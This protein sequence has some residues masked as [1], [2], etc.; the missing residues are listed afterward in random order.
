MC[1]YW[2][3]VKMSEVATYLKVLNGMSLADLKNF[4]EVVLDYDFNDVEGRRKSDKVSFIINKFKDTPK[5]KEFFDLLG[6]LEKVHVHKA[7]RYLNEAYNLPAD[8]LR[9]IKRKTTLLI[10]LYKYNLID[11]IEEIR[12][13]SGI[14]EYREK[15]RYIL[16]ITPKSNLFVNVKE[17]LTAFYK[18]WNQKRINYLF[19]EVVSVT[20]DSLMIRVFKESDRKIARQFKFRLSNNKPQEM[21]PEEFSIKTTEYY[22]VSSKH[23]NIKKINENTFEIVFNFD[24]HKDVELVEKLFSAIFGNKI[25]IDQLI[26]STPKF[27][28][29]IVDT[30][31]E[32]LNESKNESYD[33]FKQKI[34]TM[35]EEAIKKVNKLDI[36]PK[37]KEKVKVAIESINVLPPII[38]NADE[39]GIIDLK[40]LVNP[41]VFPKD[42]R[43]RRILEEAYKIAAEVE[44]DKKMYPLFIN[45]KLIV[46]LP[47]GTVKSRRLSETDKYALK[48][49]FGVENEEEG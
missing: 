38:T 6:T 21:T 47:S 16:T 44:K 34:E 35:R 11:K 8:E 37:K 28:E 24:P 27:V 49:F 33:V 40:H 30:S 9:D 1:N 7:C 19:A 15:W 2:S 31:E 48:L 18:K 23:I 22:P 29:K 3:G 13:V 45:R 14:D 46:V 10:L 12:F 32:L 4:V 20:N 43:G 39:K 5:F 25:E 26:Y 17:N 42:P 36:P 41:E